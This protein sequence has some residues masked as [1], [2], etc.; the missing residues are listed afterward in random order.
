MN[1]KKSKQINT[2]TEFP[3]LSLS[4]FCFWFFSSC[5]PTTN[6]TP[7][8]FIQV[9]ERKLYQKLN[10]KNKIDI[11]LQN[12]WLFP[13]LAAFYRTEEEVCR[14]SCPT[15]ISFIDT[16]LPFYCH[17]QTENGNY[18]VK[19]KTK[20]VLFYTFS[21]YSKKILINISPTSSIVR[22]LNK[23]SIHH[24]L[25]GLNCCVCSRVNTVHVLS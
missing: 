6:R 21:F 24:L 15:K 2:L 7:P 18:R 14:W 4:L 11:K 5:A 9:Y 20:S 12:H 13:Y 3:V 23:Y 16:N 8:L 10:K 25:N 19:Y 17:W 22:K 1:K